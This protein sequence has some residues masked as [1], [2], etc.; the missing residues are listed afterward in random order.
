MLA[1]RVPQSGGQ[2]GFAATR[3]Q[4]EIYLSYLIEIAVSAELNYNMWRVAY[5]YR[6]TRQPT[7]END[8]RACD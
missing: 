6:S 5:D 8:T 2:Q 7:N 4:L 3:V 1:T